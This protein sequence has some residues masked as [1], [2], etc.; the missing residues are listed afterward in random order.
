MARKGE[1]QPDAKRIQK[2]YRFTEKVYNRIV[3]LA[4]TYAGGNI[5]KWIT[6]GALN[7]ERKVLK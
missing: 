3:F 4:N 1:L 7:A 6:H 5:T 2:S